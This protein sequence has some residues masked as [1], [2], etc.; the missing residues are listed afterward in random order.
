MREIG[1]AAMKPLY[2]FGLGR[3]ECLPP[4]IRHNIYTFTGTQAICRTSPD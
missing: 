2:G 3:V 4:S 1:R